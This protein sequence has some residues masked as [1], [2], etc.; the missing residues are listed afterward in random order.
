MFNV[1]GTARSAS[2]V[3]QFIHKLWVKDAAKD[4]FNPDT[5]HIHLPEDKKRLF[6]AKIYLLC[7]AS[8]LRVILTELQNNSAYEELLRESE[9]LIFPPEPTAEGMKKL[10]VIKAMVAELDRFFTEKK[11]ISW[12]RGWLHKI[13]HDETNPAILATFAQLIGVNTKMVR[14]FLHDIGPPAS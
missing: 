13:G 2:Y 9:R 12:C 5:F 7:E 1:G 8:A 3:A 4:F 11:E 10:E 6:L 14:K